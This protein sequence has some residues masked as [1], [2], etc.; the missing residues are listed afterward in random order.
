MPGFY[1]HVLPTSLGIGNM[2]TLCRE[3]IALR[4]SFLYGTSLIVT[5]TVWP[6][7]ARFIQQHTAMTELFGRLILK[8]Y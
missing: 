3:G 5:E 6:A 4:N 2:V 7:L 8:R 1:G